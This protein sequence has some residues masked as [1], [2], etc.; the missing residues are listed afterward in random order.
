MPRRRVRE[1]PE[2]ADGREA[3]VSGLEIEV[4]IRFGGAEAARRAILA[5]GGVEVRARHVEDNRI[6]D[7]PAGDLAARSALLRVRA[8]G[9]GRGFVT[10]KEKVA[11]DVHA[12][13]RA[14]VEVEVSSA[15]AMAAILEAAGWVPVY[16]YQKHRTVFRMSGAAVDL[17]E[18][19][20]G[21]F[22]EIEASPEELR[23]AAA[24][25]G[26]GEDAFIVDDYRALHLRWLEERGLPRGDMV[27]GEG[28]PRGRGAP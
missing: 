25:L 27:F 18:T 6:Y 23:S 16:R 8:A 28:P 5:A 15:D 4:K 2:A 13:V 22:V 12:K 21:C 14:E 11:S 7:T 1:P 19:P 26:A 20:I 3:V 24:R 17:D 10:F 9:D